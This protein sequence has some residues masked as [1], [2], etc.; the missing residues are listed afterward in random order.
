MHVP[1]M[2]RRQILPALAGFA[3][4]PGLLRDAWGERTSGSAI[5]LGAQTNAWAIDPNHFESFLDVLGQIRSIGY[6]GFETGFLN[7]S[8]QFPSPEQRAL[9]LQRPGSLSSAFTFFFSRKNSIP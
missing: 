7:L 5:K 8:K 1:F 2:T 4:F 3:A 6:S 9:R